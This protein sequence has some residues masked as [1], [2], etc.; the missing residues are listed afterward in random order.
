MLEVPVDW[1]WWRLFAGWR[2]SARPESSDI[3]TR[4]KFLT[5]C[6]NN[7]KKHS[8]KNRT[9]EIIIISTSVSDKTL[10]TQN[11]QSCIVLDWAWSEALTRE[12]PDGSVE[13]WRARRRRSRK[14]PENTKLKRLPA[15]H[16]QQLMDTEEQQCSRH[17]PR[18]SRDRKS[19]RRSK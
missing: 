13:A 11:V 15:K 19:S 7:K 9:F 4:Q 1:L 10:A 6:Q 16:L 14:T 3:Y 2:K 12:S 17:F 8:H 18:S 5:L